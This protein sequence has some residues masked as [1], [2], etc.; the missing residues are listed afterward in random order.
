MTQWDTILENVSVFLSETELYRVLLTESRHFEVTACCFDH[1][2]SVFLTRSFWY[3]RY[4]RFY[5]NSNVVT[6]YLPQHPQFTELN[7]AHAFWK[8]ACLTAYHASAKN[9]TL[10]TNKHYKGR[11]RQL[12]ESLDRA[13]QLLPFASGLPL[14]LGASIVTTFRKIYSLAQDGASLRQLEQRLVWF[15]LSS[16]AMFGVVPTLLIIHCRCADHLVSHTVGVFTDCPWPFPNVSQSSDS[17]I[18]TSGNLRLLAPSYKSDLC[19]GNSD[20]N[21]TLGHWVWSVTERAAHSRSVFSYDLS[22]GFW[23]GGTHE[24]AALSIDCMMQTVSSWPS[25]EFGLQR[26]L[27]KNCTPGERLLIVSIDVWAPYWASQPEQL[28]PFYVAKRRWQ[29]RKNASHGAAT[30]PKC[31]QQLSSNLPFFDV[32]TTDTPKSPYENHLADDDEEERTSPGDSHCSNQYQSLHD[33]KAEN[34]KAR[35]AIIRKAL[36]RSPERY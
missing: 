4:T 1:P 31:L 14:S 35:N 27:F 8:A 2:P 32:T 28:H 17:T 29:Q 33:F 9:D 24:S 30:L 7:N 6:Q 19:T 26:T 34:N 21:S 23:F 18:P 10:S 5:S 22:R 13:A 25:S 3:N 12:V 11:R 20:I 36:Q 15:S 16:E